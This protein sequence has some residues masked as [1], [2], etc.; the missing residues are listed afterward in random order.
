MKYFSKIFLFL[1]KKLQEYLA[2][3]SKTK[4]ASIFLWLIFSLNWGMGVG[5][6]GWAVLLKKNHPKLN[7]F[8]KQPEAL[9]SKQCDKSILQNTTGHFTS[10][11][12]F[13]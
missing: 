6:G 1:N 12:V 13:I 7:N 3:T 10:S 9:P 2:S 4:D 11:L 5:G 8:G